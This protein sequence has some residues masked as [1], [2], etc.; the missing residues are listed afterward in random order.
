MSR[1]QVLQDFLKWCEDERASY[2]SSLARY[3]TGM[4]RFRSSNELGQLV[5]ATEPMMENCRRIIAE[6]D[7]LIPRITADITA[8]GGAS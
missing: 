7:E 6:M 2:A 1:V 8:A 3:E 5:D 4:M